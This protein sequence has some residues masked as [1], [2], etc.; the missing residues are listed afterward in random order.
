VARSA[1]HAG[2]R[3]TVMTP[4]VVSKLEHAFAL[5]CSD[6]EACL[7][8]DI[9]KQTLYDYQKLKPEFVDRKEKL[10]ETPILKARTSV[11]GELAND[12]DLA[13]RFLERRKKDEFST[14][15]ENDSTLK[16]DMKLEH[17]IAPSDLAILDQ[18]LNQQK[19]GK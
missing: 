10:K 9:S 19:D 7:Y 14:K 6:L 1:K 5:G 4:E 11:V 12:P 2:G 8:A 17:K 15:T 13:L 18:Y 3:P 16:A